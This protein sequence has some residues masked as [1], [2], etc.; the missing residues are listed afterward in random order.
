MRGD[1]RRFSANKTI[2]EEP[3]DAKFLAPENELPKGLHDQR[4]TPESL[5]P[6]FGEREIHAWHDP[7]RSALKKIKFA[8]ARSDLRNKLNGACSGADDRDV[9]SVEV[10]VVIPSGGVKFRPCKILEAFQARILRDV[11]ASDA[12][13]DDTRADAHTLTRG[14]MPHAIG[15]IPDCF[16]KA[17]IQPDIRREF[18]ALDATFQ[19]IV[20]FPLAGI[21]ARPIRRW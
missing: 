20:N 21:H 10:N 15:F 6:F 3:Q 11:Q 2:S 14:G 17:R 7:R 18:V 9:F 5:L 12:G 13:D 8:H 16:V 19:I 4:E 1:F